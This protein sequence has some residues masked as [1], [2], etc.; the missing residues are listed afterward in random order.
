MGTKTKIHL[1]FETTEENYINK[2]VHFR[3]SVWMEDRQISNASEASK[4]KLKKKRHS[5]LITHCKKKKNING[6][7]KKNTP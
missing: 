1:R 3:S 6:E 7:S 2:T 5:A 4:R